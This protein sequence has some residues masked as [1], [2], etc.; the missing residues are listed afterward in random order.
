MIAYRGTRAQ[1][2]D[3]LAAHGVAARA[4]YAAGG[5]RDAYELCVATAGSST[6]VRLTLRRSD[7]RAGLIVET[8]AGL[9]VLLAPFVRVSTLRAEAVAALAAAY[10]RYDAAAPW[11]T[12]IVLAPPRAG[13]FSTQH[14]PA[15]P[16]DGASLARLVTA[17]P[18]DHAR[19]TLWP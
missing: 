13:V 4:T 10:A 6:W 14:V 3:L 11:R 16:V 8:A 7:L 17:L 19:M 5:P 12:A 1:L 2:A 9:E 18:Y 15:L